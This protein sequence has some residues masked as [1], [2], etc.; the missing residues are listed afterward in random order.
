MEAN[1]WQ[2]FD[3]SASGAEHGASAAAVDLAVG[4]VVWFLDHLV[5]TLSL[6]VM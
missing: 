2:D 5:E 6:M 3:L 4:G 1:I